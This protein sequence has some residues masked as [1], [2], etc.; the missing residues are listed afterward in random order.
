MPLFYLCSNCI[1]DEAVDEI[2][3]GERFE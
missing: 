1:A 2:C 3:A